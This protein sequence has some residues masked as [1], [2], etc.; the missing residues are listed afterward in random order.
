MSN[1]DLP[2]RI[3]AKLT[4]ELDFAKEDQPLIGDVLQ[5]IIASLGISSEG[6]G[7]RTAQSHYRYKLESNLPKE[8][9]TVD[10]LFDLF[11]EAREPGEPSSAELLAESMHPDYE[12]AHAWWEG[13]NEAQRNWFVEKF[14]AVKMVTK[15]WETHR[16]MDFADRA[17]FQALS[18]SS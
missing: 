1:P 6:N 2:D 17:F 8:P 15:A 11:D 9:M 18:Q 3:K 14:P 7:S 16:D 12:Q 13:L 5:N 10:R 4:I